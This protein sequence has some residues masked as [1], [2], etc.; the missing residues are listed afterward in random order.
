MYPDIYQKASSV[1][2]NLYP[3]GEAPSDTPTPYATHQLINGVSDNY[4]ACTPTADEYTVQ[5]DVWDK[6]AS[7]VIAAA[8]KIRDALEPEYYLSFFGST[9]RDSETKLYGYVLR[10]DVR[11]DRK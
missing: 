6:T 11:E 9:A 2:P 7:G 4:L 5:V 1:F 10:F 3:F 8:K